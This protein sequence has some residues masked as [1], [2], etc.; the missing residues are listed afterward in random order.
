M[1]QEIEAKFQLADKKEHDKLRKVLEALNAPYSGH[2]FERNVFYDTR[3]NSHLKR[4]EVVRLREI[5]TPGCGEAKLV[6]SFKGK[7]KKKGK[8][9]TREEI[10]FH[11]PQAIIDVF[12][13]IRYKR[14]FEF[15]KIRR[16]YFYKGCEVVLDVLPTP[17]GG[18]WYFCEIEGPSE[19]KIEDVKKRLGYKDVKTIM[20]GYPSLLKAA[21]GGK[22]IKKI[23]FI[24]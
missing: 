2:R 6:L 20:S 21:K 16:T 18:R 4:G 1:A 14:T 11:V 23:T 22:S 19:K 5:S 17:K 10:E 12:K 3:D 24:S 7:L 8:F 15:E 9:K 13:R